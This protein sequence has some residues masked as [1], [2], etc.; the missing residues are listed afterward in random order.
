M[1][2]D[3]KPGIVSLSNLKNV[4][5]LVLFAVVFS[6]P[7]VLSAQQSSDGK[8]AT[9]PAPRYRV[10]SLRY[11]TAEQAQGFLKKTAIQVESQIVKN[12]IISIT[13][14][15]LDL[16]RAAEVLRL[17]DSQ[18][19]YE[20]ENIVPANAASSLP[21]AKEI[22]AKLGNVQVGSFANP[23]A[24]Q[25]DKAIVDVLGDK[26]LIIAPGERIEQIEKLLMAEPQSGTG[27]DEQNEAVEDVVSSLARPA[28]ANAAITLNSNNNAEPVLQNNTE[29]ETGNSG[30]FDAASLLKIDI[31]N[32]PAAN[33]EKIKKADANLRLQKDA[34][35]PAAGS[36]SDVFSKLTDSLGRKTAVDSNKVPAIPV[37]AQMSSRTAAKPPAELN[38]TK[39][40]VQAAA[41]T[42]KAND[43]ESVAD[44]NEVI[45]VSL[46]EKLS[47]I[48]LIGLVSEYLHLNYM[49]DPTKVTGDITLKLENNLEGKLRVKDLYPL[50]ESV[51]KQKGFVMSRRGNFVTIV[52]KEEVAN[53]DPELVDTSNEKI[54]K[55][56]VVI[57]RI[58]QLKFIDPESAKNLLTGMGMGLD[59]NTSASAGGFLIVTEYAYRMSR[60][61]ELISMVD[62]PGEP[63]RF[64]FR[65]L[66][67]TMASALKDK[68]K[69]LAEQLGTI[70]ITVAT[71][72]ARVMPPGGGRPL[73]RPPVQTQPTPSAAPASEALNVF[74]DVDDRTNRLLM[75]GREEQLDIIESLVDT[76]DVQQQDL[77]SLRLYEI[78]NADAQDVV[79]KLGELG[80]ISTQP[81]TTTRG[82]TTSRYPTSGRITQPGQQP[83]QGGQ[84]TSAAE[85]QEITGEEPQII[86]IEATNAL[87]VNAT[88]EQHLRIA[89]MIGYIDSSPAEASTNY[90]VYPL[91][92]QDPEEMAKVLNQLIHETV[93]NKDASGKVVG[94]TITKKTDEEIAIIPDKNTFAI[95]VYASKKNQQWVESLIRQLDRRRPQVLI[96]VTLVEVSKN[97]AFNLDLNVLTKGPS[98]PLVGDTGN[99]SLAI[100]FSVDPCSKKPVGQKVWGGSTNNGTGSA[101]YGDNH[102]QAL[103]TA[104]DKKGYGRVLAKPKLLVNDNAT[105]TIKTSEVQTIVS[106]Q[107][108]IVTS[109]SGPS[110]STASVTNTP[111]TAEI[112][113]D[114]T[115]HISEGN[116]LRLEITMTRTDFRAR[117]DYVL[118]AGSG[119]GE[120]SG[121]SPPD[122]LTSDVKT[123]ITVPDD[124]TIILGG[125]EKLNQSKGGTK[126]PI[127]G[128]LPFIGGAFRST[129]NTDTQDRM[130]VFVKAN[131]LRPE[132]RG[133][134][135]DIIRISDKNRQDFE[136]HE[137]DMQDYQDWPGIKPTPMAPKKIFDPNEK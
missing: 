136:K 103:L 17:V 44:G 12:N 53:I 24:G 38:Q 131:I 62:K 128:D 49:Y 78:Q 27:S 88:A 39:P 96:D 1:Y 118:K 45:S 112:K 107:S 7:P 11:I 36:L 35:P 105:G 55:G 68:I 80:I 65:R 122:L 16:A 74:I 32:L 83:G 125:L 69:A 31:N 87:L 120:L 130:Y 22:S 4:L 40:N 89:S 41:K 116:L 29:K 42:S 20:V 15:Q 57:T 121:P 94:T 33:K 115:P 129:A 13:A 8:T 85:I 110:A 73:I 75:I 97:D 137:K 58:F 50:L 104:M 61:E 3:G 59:I 134:E 84:P 14:Q 71:P 21:A 63:K 23:P 6:C 60:V 26:V 72:A 102:I 34:N 56:D 54:Q 30:L 133:M 48:Q 95:I 108:S 99:F 90:V 5:W 92:S 93:E 106:A 117:P 81:K 76:L 52:P 51:M 70:S 9:A 119:G 135:S 46:P 126:V 127:L 10:F 43:S 79:S 101:F 132:Q 123:V 19:P 100:P 113:L 111:Y 77:R 66:K 82:S 28:D 18:K 98:L 64:H 2:V 67:Y 86:V 124:R 109:G 47:I 91:E 37:K 25:G 114:I